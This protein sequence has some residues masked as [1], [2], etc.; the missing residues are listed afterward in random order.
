MA[1]SGLQS[2]GINSIAEDIDGNMWIGTSNGL[3]KFYWTGWK[4]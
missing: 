3:S 1:N 4:T 2:D